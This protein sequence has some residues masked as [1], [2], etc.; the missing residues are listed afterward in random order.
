MTSGCLR[1]L[2]HG[3]LSKVTVGARLQHGYLGGHTP[4]NNKETLKLSTLSLPHVQPVVS[5]RV[6]D[7]L[8][9]SFSPSVLMS[10]HSSEGRSFSSPRLFMHIFILVWLC[11][12]L[13]RLMGYSL[14]LSLFTS[15]SQ[16]F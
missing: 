10:G 13:L 5:A 6:E 16:L 15:V 12:I 2:F 4:V 1:D 8:A 7:F 3:S 11:R 14:L 9:T